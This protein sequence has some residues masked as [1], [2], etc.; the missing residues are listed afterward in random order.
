[1]VGEIDW[2]GQQEA[3]RGFVPYPGTGERRT[4][5]AVKAEEQMHITTSGTSVVKWNSSNTSL[6]IEDHTYFKYMLRTRELMQQ[7]LTSGGLEST[8][9]WSPQ[10]AHHKPLP[11]KLRIC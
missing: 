5:R 7:F 2:R 11:S 9:V 4:C 6:Q 1:M 10:F 3:I 8:A